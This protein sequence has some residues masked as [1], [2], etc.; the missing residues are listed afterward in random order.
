MNELTKSDTK[1]STPGGYCKLLEVNDIAVRWYFD[2]NSLT[3]MT[4]IRVMILN[5]NFGILPVLLMHP[6]AVAT[7]KNYKETEDAATDM[8]HTDAWYVVV[9]V[10]VSTEWLRLTWRV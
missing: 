8:G 2:S 9:L 3:C 4:G 5:P 1:W 7:S 10:L 6:E